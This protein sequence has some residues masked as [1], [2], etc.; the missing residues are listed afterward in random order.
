VKLALSLAVVIALT[1]G[2]AGLLPGQTPGDAKTPARKA[3]RNVIGTVRSSSPDTVVVTGREKG[4]DAEW[5]FAVD[6]TTDIRKGSKAIVP[7]SIKPG[8]G[9]QVRFV[10]RNGRAVAEW[11]R[12]REVR[13]EASTK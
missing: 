10:E 1:L 6:V 13:K 5:T 12:V 9:V 4:K 2:S 8:D 11:I 7:T 3:T